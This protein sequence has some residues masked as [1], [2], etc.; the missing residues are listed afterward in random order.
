MCVCVVSV[1]V[2][3]AFWLQWNTYRFTFLFGCVLFYLL[4]RHVLILNHLSSAMQPGLLTHII[5]LLES[6][7][8]K[9][10]LWVNEVPNRH[11]EDKT[12]PDVPGGLYY[13]K[14]NCY[15]LGTWTSASGE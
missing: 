8:A 6:R 9:L 7:E 3:Y 2:I 5:S 1:C 13:M 12:K 14:E 4:R 11:N 15:V 10:S